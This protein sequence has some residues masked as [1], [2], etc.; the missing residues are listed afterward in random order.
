MSQFFIVNQKPTMQPV[1][2][3]SNC[4]TEWVFWVKFYSVRIIE[5]TPAVNLT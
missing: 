3:K 5:S 2:C 1:Y 4:W